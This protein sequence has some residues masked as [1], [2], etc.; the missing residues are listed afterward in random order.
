MNFKRPKRARTKC[1]DRYRQRPVVSSH[2]GLHTQELWRVGANSSNCASK[3][4]GRPRPA[5][6][7]IPPRHSG[8]WM[9][10]AAAMKLSTAKVWGP[11]SNGEA[12]NISYPIPNPT[13]T[14]PYPTQP[15]PTLPY[16]TLPYHTQPYRESNPVGAVFARECGH[17]QR[18]A[19][20]EV[21]QHVQY[22]TGVPRS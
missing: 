11:F 10:R 15:Y 13:P 5:R 7:I 17:F 9:P 16:H 14:Q 21:Q 8:H 4:L 22:G 18:H 12:S 3:Q 6:L 1:R 19:A 2:D 20:C